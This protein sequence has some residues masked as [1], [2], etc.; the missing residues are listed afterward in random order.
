MKLRIQAGLLAVVFAAALGVGFGTPAEAK[1]GKKWNNNHG[2]HLG[3]SKNWKRNN[4]WRWRNSRSWN[5]NRSW[6]RNWNHNR[7]WNANRN[8]NHNRNWNV[9]RNWNDRNWSANRW[10]RWR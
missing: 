10:D 4:D 5:Q 3:W 2:R 6:N 9:N 8:W 7:S 1:H